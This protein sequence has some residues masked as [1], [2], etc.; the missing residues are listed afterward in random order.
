M[1]FYIIS[2][3]EMDRGNRVSN[4]STSH[5]WKIAKY[6]VGNIDWVL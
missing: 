5:F 4:S 6:H 1:R 2:V 3:L